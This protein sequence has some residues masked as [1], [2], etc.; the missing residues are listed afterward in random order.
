MFCFAPFMFCPKICCVFAIRDSFEGDA[1]ACMACCWVSFVWFK[2]GW[3]FCFDLGLCRVL[4]FCFSWEYRYH[5][6]L[7]FDV[8]YL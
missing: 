2:P 4:C 6:L 3:L 5:V 7:W 1:A 8:L